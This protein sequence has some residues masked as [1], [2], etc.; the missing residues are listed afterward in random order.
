MIVYITMT[1]FAVFFSALANIKTYKKS[2][3]KYTIN[4][5]LVFWHISEI[6]LI[7]VAAIRY[8]V[9]QDYMY[10]YVPYFNGVLI[11]RPNENIEMGFYV[12]NK[13]VQLFTKDYAGI[14]IVC[15]VFFFHYIYKAIRE[16]SV[17]PTLSV[18]L[19]V[20]TT[21]YFIFLNTMRQM[22]VVAVF[23][24]AIKYIKQRNLKKFLLYMILASTIHVS[25]VIC[26]PLYF[27]YGITLRP[28]KACIL[29]GVAIVA[30][31]IVSRIV[32]AIVSLTKYNYYIDSRFDTNES[33]YIVL[34]M[35][36]C[37]LIFSLIYY[38]RKNSQVGTL[39]TNHSNDKKIKDYSYY[40][41]LQLLSTIMAWYNNAVPLLNR[42]RWATGISIIILI[43]LT[44]MQEK[45]PKTRNLYIF[46]IVILYSIYS[47]YTIG[48]NNANNV[49]P[50]LTIFQR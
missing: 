49:L 12:L 28:I 26:I 36:V 27:L 46:L 19:L 13:V 38:S 1:I 9:G 23:L 39:N 20:G 16:Q 37:V 47:L 30:K 33:G 50:Y 43:P 32:L 15:S 34:A 44:I 42:V 29:L 41:L 40:C 4:L 35:N 31:P 3:K 5:K 8:D 11:G 14:F 6:I 48:V 17:M 22:M 2:K 18:F 7:V 24:Y 21:Y 45:N 25:A 10:T